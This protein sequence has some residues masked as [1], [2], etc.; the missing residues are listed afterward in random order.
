MEERKILDIIP[1]EE[2]KIEEVKEKKISLPKKIIKEQPSFSFPQLKWRLF[3]IAILL[4][5][6]TFF[7]LF[8]RQCYDTPF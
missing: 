2:K 3:F 7:Q 4:I 8:L 1:P 5:L 6:L